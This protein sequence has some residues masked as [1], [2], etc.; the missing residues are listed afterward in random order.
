MLNAASPLIWKPRCQVS[1]NSSPVHTTFIPSVAE[2]ASTVRNIN[3]VY[4]SAFPPYVQSG[5]TPHYEY[6]L[7]SF[8]EAYDVLKPS[9]QHFLNCCGIAIQECIPCH[10][11]P[12]NVR[13]T[14]LHQ[15]ISGRSLHCSPYLPP[16]AEHRRPISSKIQSQQ[17]GRVLL[18]HFS[19]VFPWPQLFV[20]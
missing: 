4:S 11:S 14:Q 2:F 19:S 10:R 17:A 6:G 12:G 9:P 1:I 3:V 5:L 16:Q 20:L 8:P 13:S 7:I 18:R 15:T